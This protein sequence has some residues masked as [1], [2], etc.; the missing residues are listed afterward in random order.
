MKKRLIVIITIM[1]SML[2]PISTTMALS[3]VDAKEKIDITRLCSL[4]LL[5]SSG[6]M[7]FDE[8]NVQLY[9]VAEVSEDFQY[10]LIGKFANYPISINDISSQSEWKQLSTTLNS[11]MLA[12]N[13]SPTKTAIT[14]HN[15]KAVFSD[16]SCGLYLVSAVDA[17]ENNQ[18]YHFS[19][20]VLSI[21]IVNDDGKLN[22][23]INAKPKSIKTEPV[24]SQVEY[25]AVKLWKDSN[26]DKR[27]S[28]VEIAIYKNG[29]FQESKTLNSENN[30]SYFWRAVD[31]GS[32][33]TV[34]ERN[35]PNGY[36]VSIEKNAKSFV[37]VNTSSEKITT[38][39]KTGDTN[40]KI[41]TIAFATLGTALIITVL[42]ISRKRNKLNEKI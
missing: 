28:S 33:W 21:P 29:E 4:E 9:K 12:D 26:S 42:I 10:T 40:S 16:L 27:P 41:Y 1:L 24:N 25:E 5:Y 32:E 36:K 3:S 2:M 17:A 6:E 22:Y 15:G 13:I 19:E 20:F 30:W 7:Q 14:D 31:D 8:L 34:V 39:P 37:I 23:S 11:Y 35:I 38:P 18:I